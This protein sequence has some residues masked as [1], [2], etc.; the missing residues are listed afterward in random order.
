VLERFD[1]GHGLGEQG[2]LRGDSGFPLLHD[3]QLVGDSSLYPIFHAL[4]EVLEHGLLVKLGDD[5]TQVQDL[6]AK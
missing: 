3:C 5:V 2:L 6:C 4:L 1:A